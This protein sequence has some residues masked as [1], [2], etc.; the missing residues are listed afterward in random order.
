MPSKYGA[1][2]VENSITRKL[3]EKIKQYN[4]SK[5]NLKY[6]YVYIEIPIT[7]FFLKRKVGEVECGFNRRG[8][9]DALLIYLLLVSTLPR[10][11]LFS[12]LSQRQRK[13]CGVLIFNER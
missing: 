3:T 13:I 7:T 11:R 6:I 9:F 12:N 10:R 8:W 5:S 2:T 4:I 1:D